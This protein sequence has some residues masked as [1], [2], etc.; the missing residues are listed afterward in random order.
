MAISE[1]DILQILAWLEKSDWQEL[2]LESGTFKLTV[3][4][5]GRPSALRVEATPSAAAPLVATRSASREPVKPAPAAPRV[6]R[7]TP[8]PKPAAAEPV[9]PSWIAVK[10]PTLGNFYVAPQPG[11]PPFV[12]LGQR[13]GPDDTVAIVEVMKLM[14]HVKAEAS[15]R[16]ARVC[17]QNGDLVEYEQVLF[18]IDPAGAD[19]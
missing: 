17:A 9:D 13:V 19:A 3:S 4:K 1:K 5:T 11:A 2:H 16:I 15:G 7:P 8:A 18:L 14:N 10:S 6:T 12:T